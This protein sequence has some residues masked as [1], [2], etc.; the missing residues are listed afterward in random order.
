MTVNASVQSIESL[1]LTLAKIFNDFYV[2]PSFQ[3]EYVWETEQV[4]QLLNDI[5][6]EF[7]ED[8]GRTEYFIGSLVVCPGNDGTLDLI[9][10]Q[11]RMTT[12]YLFL[13]AVPRPSQDPGGHTSQPAQS[14]NCRPQYER[15][16]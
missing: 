9:D 15:C 10:G 11:Q 14:A 5:Y 7:T 6:D 13:C 8:Q 4:E 12:S 16:G 2:V 3:R 1:D